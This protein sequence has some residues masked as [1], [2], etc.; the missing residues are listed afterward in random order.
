[1]Q[2]YRQLKLWEKS[3]HLTL[4]AYRTTSTF[5][6]DEIYGLT[7]QLR[8][9]SSSDPS[10]IVEGCGLDTQA[11]FAA[12]LF[13]V[14]GS[15]NEP[16]YRPLLCRDLGYLKPDDYASVSSASTEVKR[17]LS[18]LIVNGRRGPS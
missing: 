5:P 1:V 14:L 10:N 6:R 13:R 16:E 9:C 12:A 8:R 4:S 3:H 7:S 11:Q 18:T 15:A 2:D 17:M